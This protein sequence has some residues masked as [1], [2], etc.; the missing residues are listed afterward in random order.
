M[1]PR[2][3][4]ELSGV[5]RGW[6]TRAMVRALGRRV[7]RAA[8]AMGCGPAQVDGITLRIVHDDRMQQLKAE[9]LGMAEA[10]D[11]LAFP[12][13]AGVPGEDDPGLGEIV[14]NRDA[15]ARQ[16]AAPG[17]AGWLDEATALAIHGVAHLRGHDHHQRTASRRMLRCERRGS[18]A[19]GLT[20]VRPYG[21]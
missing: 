1:T 20:C 21:G 5:E 19:V 18:R 4:L 13:G 2:V 3:D 17:E 10:T 11:V 8:F 6:P 16:A 15:I 9:H 12:A 7:R 14:L